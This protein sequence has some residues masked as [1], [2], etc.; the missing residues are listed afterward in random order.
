MEHHSL[1]EFGRLRKKR[2][3]VL[4]CAR[5]LEHVHGIEGGGMGGGEGGGEGGGMGGGMGGGEGGGGDG[6]GGGGEFLS[7]M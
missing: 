4:P 5:A 1:C 6:G 3:S 7:A 2:F